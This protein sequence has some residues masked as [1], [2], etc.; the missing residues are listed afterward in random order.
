MGYDGI[1]AKVLV[2]PAGIVESPAPADPHLMIHLGGPVE[3]QCERAGNRH[4]GITI[5]GD[6]DI[7]PTG[8]SSRWI[9]S[10]QDRALLVR[11]PQDCLDRVAADSGINPDRAKLL[12]RFQVRD[13][14]LEQLAWAAKAELDDPKS[15]RLYLEGICIALASRL[16]H[17][18]SVHE[19]KSGKVSSRGM[20]GARLRR[21]LSFIEDNLHTDLT[22]SEI[23]QVSGLSVTQCQRAFRAALGV[24]IYQFIISQ[25]VMRAASLLEETG[26]SVLD[27]AFATGFSHP[28]HLSLHMRRVIGTSPASLRRRAGAQV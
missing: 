15:G 8:V 17:V 25:R 14:S 22:L 7:I 1:R 26:L 11:I 13:P 27:V 12:N 18:H 28:S 6:V 19:N 9:L 16:L 4:R 10:R 21:V 2:D 3:I 20:S 5:H 23:A 24:S